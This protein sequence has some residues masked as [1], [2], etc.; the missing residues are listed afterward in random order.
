MQI[1]QTR[2]RKVLIVGSTQGV[3]GGIEAFMLSVASY[4]QKTGKFEVRVCF[5]LVKGFTWDEKLKRMA[6]DACG[7]DVF[8]VGRASLELLKHIYWA[9][10]L[11]VQN[12]PPD[13]VISGFISS[14][15][16]FLTIHNWKRRD[17]GFHSLVWRVCYELADRRWFN[18]NFVWNSYE[19]QVKSQKS[20]CVPTVCNLM[21]AYLEPNSRKGFIF[22]GRWI[23]NKGLEELLEA[24]SLGHLDS[25]DT[26]LVILGTG[27]LKDKIDKL[28]QDYDLKNVIFPG[29]VS[30]TVKAEYLASARWLVAPAK[31]KEDLGLTPIEARFVSVPSIVTNDGGL[32][33]SGGVGAL[34]VEPGDVFG[35]SKAM[36]LAI[37]MDEEEYVYRSEIGKKTLDD[38]LKPLSFY[39]EQFLS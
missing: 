20:A 15:K 6:I 38:F 37:A 14:K 4:L 3:Y 12:M 33:E 35:L 10:V 25:E 16:I 1:R 29:F 22:V 36:E 26:P 11:H 9:D 21:P 5:K 32:P 8:F 39:E 31:T 23:E 19:P 13:I 34:V 30:D 7:S 18:S 24:Y 28:V 17:L 27:P 2:K